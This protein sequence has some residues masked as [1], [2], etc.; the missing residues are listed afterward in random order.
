MMPR[1][2]YRNNYNQPNMT[3]RLLILLVTVGVSSLCLAQVPRAVMFPDLTPDLAYKAQNPP[4]FAL[5]TNLVYWGAMVPQV[6]P[7]LGMEFGLS[8]KMTLSL[9]G[10]YNP[11]EAKEPDVSNKKLKH[12][13]FEPEVRYW[14]CERFNGHAIGVH[15]IVGGFNVSEY[16]IPM[17]FHKEN[18]YFGNILRL[19][20]DSDTPNFNIGAIGVGASYNYHWMVGKHFGIEF[21]LGLGFMY[22]QYERFDCEVCSTPGEEFYLT[23]LGPTKIGINLIYIIK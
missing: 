1:P 23:Y 17:L 5:R 11:W 14:F 2:K 7:N 4:A 10:A 21:S 15:A 9:I 8:K 22:L 13:V 6:T 16:N 18:R 20:K 3:K 19:P 12:W